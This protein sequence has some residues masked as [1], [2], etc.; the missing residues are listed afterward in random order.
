MDDTAD[1]PADRGQTDLELAYSPSSMTGGSSAPFE[2]QYRRLSSA[3]R[4][5]HAE[6]LVELPGGTLVVDGRSP[7]APLL[8]FVHGGYW[9]ALSAAESLFLAADLVPAGWAFAAVEY[10]LAPRGTIDEMVLECTR[11]LAQL[12]GGR[13]RVVLVGHSAGAHLVA[14]AAL[15]QK[16]PLRVDTVVLVSG[17]YD[18]RPLVHTS[19]NAPLGLDEAHAARLSPLAAPTVVPADVVVA[20]AESDTPAFIDQSRRYADHLESHGCRVRR[21]ESAGRHHFDVLFDIGDPRS[22]LGGAVLNAR[23]G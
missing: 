11:A 5:Q 2:A 3:V 4:D 23:T 12:G 15:V 1:T 9:Q 6:R 19:I 13:R 16:P 17:V 22:T 21:V 8:V 18:L 14:M 20:W 10:T 7:D